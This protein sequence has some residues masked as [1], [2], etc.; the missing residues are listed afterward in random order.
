MKY[1]NNLLT[2]RNMKGLQQGEVAI[3]VDMKQPEYSKMERGERR[4]GDHLEKLTKFFKVD[5]SAIQSQDIKSNHYKQKYTED[6]PLFGMPILNGEGV[7]MHTQFVSHTIRPDYLVDNLKSYACFIH[8]SLL[9]PR[10]EHGDL[11]YVDPNKQPKEG[12]YVVVQVK[13]GDHI[14]GIFRKLLQITDRQMKFQTL[15]PIKEEVIKN[16]EMLYV[17]TIVGTRTNFY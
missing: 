17:H 1:P 5:A 7:Q 2:L 8:G 15:H 10:Y 13:Q 12:D 9:S 11:V 14:T 4:I 16:S 3:A 6:L